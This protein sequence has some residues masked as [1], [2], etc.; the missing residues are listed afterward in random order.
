MDRAG[1]TRGCGCECEFGGRDGPGL[2][3]RFWRF[4]WG[5]WLIGRAGFVANIVW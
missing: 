4:I 2:P 1:G 3:R 5:A